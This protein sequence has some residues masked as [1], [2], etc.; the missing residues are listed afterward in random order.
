MI[1]QRIPGAGGKERRAERGH[2]GQQHADHQNLAGILPEADNGGRDEADNDQRH[3]E[4][5]NLTEDVAHGHDHIHDAFIGHKAQ[6]RADDDAAE[7]FEN[8]RQIAHFCH[9]KTSFLP[10]AHT[11][12]PLVGGHMSAAG[13][14][15]PGRFSL[16]Q[17]RRARNT[18]AKKP[19]PAAAEAY[20]E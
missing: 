8:Q 5:N 18:T 4:E 10:A 9:R 2:I 12:R 7:Q 3:K 20:P 15:Q 16:A 17:K 11:S 13:R 19:F 14:K 6:Q 1:N